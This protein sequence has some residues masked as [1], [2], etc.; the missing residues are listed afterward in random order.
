M[1][2]ATFLGYDDIDNGVHP[3]VVWKRADRRFTF[4]DW[5]KIFHLEL[6]TMGVNGQKRKKKQGP[7][8]SLEE[9]LPKKFK[10][11][12]VTK[13]KKAEHSV[14]TTTTPNPTATKAAAKATPKAT[15]NSIPIAEK[16]EHNAE[17]EQSFG[18]AK[19]SLF[20]SEDG[21]DDEFGL[22]EFEGLDGDV[23]KYP[24]KRRISNLQ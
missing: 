1:D 19:A 15:P 6:V 21:E 8:P 17:N 22:D 13:A 4:H 23:D 2:A 20:D 11:D 16:V 24:L 12:K 18:T 9:S 7:V 10:S 5:R 3:V 14:K